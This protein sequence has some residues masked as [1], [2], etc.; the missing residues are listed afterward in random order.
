[1]LPKCCHA[2][3]G[4]YSKSEE[5][6]QAK[7]LG[8]ITLFRMY[9]DYFNHHDLRSVVPAWHL[10][11]FSRQPPAD[12]HHGSVL[13]VSPTGI[14]WEQ[15]LVR[16]P[17]AVHDTRDPPLPAMRVSG[18]H[19]I[20]TALTVDIQQLRAGS[21]ETVPDIP[22][23]GPG[24]RRLRTRMS[25]GRRSVRKMNW[26]GLPWMPWTKRNPFPICFHP[27]TVQFRLPVW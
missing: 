18:Q 6:N 13:L 19:Q 10:G 26:A 1:M 11:G 5:K 21:P 27:C 17:Q 20:E 7:S 15:S 8:F 24:S 23:R 2:W 14:S 9:R 12:N 25:S 4:H 16:C 22:R 3:Q